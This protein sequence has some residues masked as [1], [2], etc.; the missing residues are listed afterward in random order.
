MSFFA[1]SNQPAV[2]PALRFVR[3]DG[4]PYLFIERD[5]QEEWYRL[6]WVGEL[7]LGTVMEGGIALIKLMEQQPYPRLL[8]DHREL[9]GSFDDANQWI[10]EVCVPMLVTRGLRCIGQILSPDIFAL[11]EME[12]LT[13]RLGAQVA[14]RLF[15]DEESAKAWL[16][17][18]PGLSDPARTGEQARAAVPD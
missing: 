16:R 6:R 4:S 1:S 18:Q 7:T 15:G 12:S 14:I 13:P 17:M 11:L 2:L 5:D 8:N 10:L 3:P 9:W